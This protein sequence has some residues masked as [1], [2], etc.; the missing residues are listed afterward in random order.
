MKKITTLNLERRI[1]EI[2]KVKALENGISCSE[3]VEA[4][5]N[6]CS[7]NRQDEIQRKISNW[8]IIKKNYK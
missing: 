2:M 6:E 8:K 5:I 1:I 4:L 3:L 7:I